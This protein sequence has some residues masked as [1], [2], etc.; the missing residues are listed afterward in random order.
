MLLLFHPA[1]LDPNCGGGGGGTKCHSA[2]FSALME[3]LV[4]LP[5]TSGANRSL[6]SVDHFWWTK[7]SSS[8][9]SELR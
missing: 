7:V 4:K 3:S 9:V 8:E 5:C 2:T 1:R 6:R